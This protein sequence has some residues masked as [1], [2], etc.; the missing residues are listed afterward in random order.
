VK[1]L[2]SGLLLPCLTFISTFA[3]PTVRA[4]NPPTNDLERGKAIAFDRNAGNCLACHAIDDGELPG[5]S[6]PP[7]MQMA[8]RFPDR[9]VLRAQ[10]W[11]ATVR[12]PNTVM[13]PYGKHKILSDEEL[14]L[15]VDYL[16]TL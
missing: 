5:N 7:L 3:I 2:L 15:V 9:D 11:D 4:E 13:P 12:N 14:D 16:L 8:L 10:I 6:G 1:K